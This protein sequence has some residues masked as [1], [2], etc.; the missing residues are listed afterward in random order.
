MAAALS[1]ASP[2]RTAKPVTGLLSLLVLA[3]GCLL[4]SPSPS[5][6]AS[7]SSSIAASTPRASSSARASASTLA[8]PGAL[9]P[10][11]YAKVL[12]DGLRI[13]LKARADATAVGAL[14]V[15]DVVRIRADAGVSGG[16]HWYEIETIQTGTDQHLTGYIAGATGDT[17]YL[18][19]MS[20]P[21]TPKPSA[22][23]TSSAGPSPSASG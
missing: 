7:A 14:F 1:L 23:P 4:G 11:S 19:A 8:S 12:V 3:S 16:I 13:R 17:A 2:H 15:N 22:T 5:A 21:P 6:T 10:G 9:G 18:E 20:G